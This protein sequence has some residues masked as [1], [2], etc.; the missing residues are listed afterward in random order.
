LPKILTKKLIGVTI[1]KKI[2][3][4]TIGATILPRASPNFIQATFSGFNIF[5][6]KKAIAKNKIAML[7]DQSLIEPEVKI[8]HKPIRKKTIANV[9]PSF[10]SDDLCIASNY[11][12]K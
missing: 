8:G 6:I 7:S 1:V 10:F 3:A 4:I 2:K 5:G 9:I 11:S 12:L